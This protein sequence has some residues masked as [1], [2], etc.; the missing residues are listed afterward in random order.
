MPIV[1]RRILLVFL[2][3]VSLSGCTKSFQ[4]ARGSNADVSLF[5]DFQRGDGRAALVDKLL[6]GKIDAPVRPEAPFN[7]GHV[8]STGFRTRQ[9]W[10]NLVFLADMTRGGWSAQTSRR[11]L[12]EAG[13]AALTAEP[14]AYR[15]ASDIW[16]DG[17]SVL[18]IHAVSEEA[19]RD[20]LAREAEAIR[21]G[22]ERRVVD[23][24]KQTL[25]VSGE[26]TSLSDGI[27]RR[28]G[29]R[30]RVPKDF[31]IEEQPDNR[32][33][34]LKQMMPSGAMLYL[35][36]YYQEQQADT[37]NPYFAMA[38]R[39]TLASIYSQGDRIEYSRTKVTPCRFLGRDAYEI[40]GLYQNLNPPMGGPFRLYCF[41]DNGR[42]YLI[43]LSVFNPPA[44]KLPQLRILQAV[45][46]SFAA[47]ASGG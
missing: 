26:Q 11:I 27:L 43:D 10:R 29:Y 47:E 1:P 19:L 17:Q 20:L 4:M 40:Y 45:A 32:F 24:L 28:H 34:R 31:F 46:E 30:I 7:V 9:H 33:V 3:L 22:F 35:F 8:D 2:A 14:A 39:D 21:T 18:F 44:D 25:Y 23:G 41:H 6:E 38:V 15:F 42:L 5:S 16:A 12:G 36:V 13:T 37:L